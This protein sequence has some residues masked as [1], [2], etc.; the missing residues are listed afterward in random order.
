MSTLWRYS[1]IFPVCFKEPSVL[2]KSRAVSRFYVSA[3]CLWMKPAKFAKRRIFFNKPNGKKRL[4][5]VGECLGWCHHS[6][7]C[8]MFFFDFY[9]RKKWYFRPQMATVCVSVQ[10]PTVQLCSF[11]LPKRR[12]PCSTLAQHRHCVR[13]RFILFPCEGTKCIKSLL[14]FASCETL[15]EPPIVHFDCK[16]SG[17]RFKTLSAYVRHQRSLEMRARG[18]LFRSKLQP[19]STASRLCTLRKS[20]ACLL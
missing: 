6:K 8:T 7:H 20:H 1:L 3:R 11:L 12:R 2:L 15:A 4:S 18:D 16:L 13:S 17:K 19:S 14:C 9:R 10:R 5:A